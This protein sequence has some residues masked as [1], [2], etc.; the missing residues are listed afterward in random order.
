MGLE[1]SGF[2]AGVLQ[3]FTATATAGGEVVCTGMAAVVKISGKRRHCAVIGIARA[4]GFASTTCATVSAAFATVVE[5]EDVERGVLI[6]VA[7]AVV[8]LLAAWS[9]R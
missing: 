8:E 6:V 9:S 4:G 5:L 1:N 7:L 3:R 2:E